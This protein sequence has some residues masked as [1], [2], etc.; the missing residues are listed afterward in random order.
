M[1]AETAFA[2]LRFGAP[3]MFIYGPG[4]HPGRWLQLVA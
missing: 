4:A 3:G 2:F 1:F